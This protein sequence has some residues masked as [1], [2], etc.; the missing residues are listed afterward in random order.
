MACQSTIDS[1]SVRPIPAELRELIRLGEPEHD[2]H[3]GVTFDLETPTTAR[4]GDFVPE[5]D[6]GRIH[7]E[8]TPG[9]LS[10][11]E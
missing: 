9:L 1:S 10:T 4:T 5:G 11:V 6:L 2:R 8:L 7:G 3:G